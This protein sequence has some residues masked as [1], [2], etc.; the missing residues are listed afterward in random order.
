MLQDQFFGARA[1]NAV[2]GERKKKKARDQDNEMFC[3]TYWSRRTEVYGCDNR[4]R[5]QT[6]DVFTST[7]DR[8]PLA[9]KRFVNDDAHPGRDARRHVQIPVCIEQ[10]LYSGLG[11]TVRILIEDERQHACP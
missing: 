6:F 9:S 5:H 7:G 10:M 8:T 2:D 1:V 4:S 11:L 3:N